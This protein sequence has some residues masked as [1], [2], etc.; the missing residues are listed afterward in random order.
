MAAKYLSSESVDFVVIGSGAAGGVVAKELSTAG[1]QVI[2]LEQ[3]PYLREKDFSHDEIA[4]F[5][6]PL[7]NDPELQP[8]TFR[9]TEM[10]A[11]KIRRVVGYGRQV[12]GGTVHYTANYWRFH[13]LDFHERSA[14][15]D[16]P[17]TGFADWPITYAELEPYYT[18]AEWEIGISGLGGSNPFDSFRSKPYPL[19]PMP[20]KSSGVLFEQGAR[21]LGLHPF[22]APMA[23]LSQNYQGRA[24]CSN[25]GFCQAYGCEVG[26]KSSSLATVIRMAERTGKCEIRADSYVRKIETNKAGRVT[27]VTYFDKSRNEVR[28]N[29]KAAVVCANGAETPR[30]LLMSKS[31]RFPTGL[32]NS[33]GLVG[34]YLMFDVNTIAMASFEHELN[35]YKSA[36]VTRVVHDYYAADPKRGFY[37]GGAFDARF[38]FQPISF[39]AR[40]LP[41]DSPQ[42]GLEFKKNV[43]E[44]FTRT[45]Q[46]MSHLTCLPLYEN[47]ISLDSEVKDA[48]NLPALRATFHLHPDDISNMKFILARQ[49]EVLKAA[50]ARKV[51]TNGVTEITSSVHL[52]GTC[53][54]GNDPSKSV[55]DRFHRAHDVKNLFIV[56]GSSF[57]TSARQQPTC[58]IQALAYRAS[59]YM[60]QRAKA[61]EI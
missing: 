58:T 29:A 57:V 18:K 12:G 60:I 6:S 31:N 54:M 1:F 52:M 11:A 8:N 55:T 33:S 36:G 7:T 22:P 16:I 5:H 4:N 21:R 3:G 56:D 24:A 59:D 46:S 27:G 49:I 47:S 39:A 53:R 51:W 44:S 41:K 43:K 37:G 45:M 38:S 19:P 20:V 10:E 32:A 40:G 14:W 48:W 35:D 30:L 15:G 23:I 9:K 25:C 28:Q 61:G 17:G 13:E 42:W 50:G 26:A 2:V 34:R